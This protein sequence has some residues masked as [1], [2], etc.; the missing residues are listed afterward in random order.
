MTYHPKDGKL[1]WNHYIHAIRVSKREYPN[2]YLDGNA[3][4][5]K[6]IKQNSFV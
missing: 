4:K 6:K 5:R 1:S 2:P 3:T